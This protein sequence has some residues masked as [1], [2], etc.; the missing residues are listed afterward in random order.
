[1]EDRM[2]VS[3]GEVARRVERLID[4]LHAR[5]LRLTHQRLEVVREIAA[6]DEH[7]DVETIYRGVKRRIPT[8]S[9][10]TVYRTL[11]TLADAGLIARLTATT[12]PARFDA[13]TAQ[14]HHFVCTRCGLVR[15]IVDPRLDQVRSP[16][17]TAEFGRVES[18]DV[19]LRGICRDCAGGST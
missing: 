2:P 5:G 17:Q 7:P 14:H 11:G 4:A 16:A 1:M 12:G 3:P 8:I 18:A 10:D 19:H 13:N 9:L 6:T 15:D